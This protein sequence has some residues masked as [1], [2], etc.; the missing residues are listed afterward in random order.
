MLPFLPPPSLPL[1]ESD[2][3]KRVNTDSVLFSAQANGQ[4][5]T[6]VIQ[7]SRQITDI[8]R[9]NAQFN[10]SQAMLCLS[11]LRW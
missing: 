7:T 5:I 6:Q 11:A 3:R 9:G 2:A 8:S 10:L 1:R 4:Q